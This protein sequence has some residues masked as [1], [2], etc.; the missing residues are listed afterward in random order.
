MMSLSHLAEMW[1]Y[2]QTVVC[3]VK[4]ESSNSPCKTPTISDL[5]QVLFT[6]H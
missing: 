5:S 2:S 3:K 1:S 6:W 4:D